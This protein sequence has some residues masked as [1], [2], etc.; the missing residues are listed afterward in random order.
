MID[1][2]IS[3]NL[4]HA[5]FLKVQESLEHLDRTE[6]TGYLQLEIHSTVPEV[7][8]IS[9]SVFEVFFVLTVSKIFS[10]Y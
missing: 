9:Q 1:D 10:V 5:E 4:F 8:P 7:L 3:E 6:F 2:R